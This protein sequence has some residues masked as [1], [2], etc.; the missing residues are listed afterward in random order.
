MGDYEFITT[1]EKKRRDKK[2]RSNFTQAVPKPTATTAVLCYLPIP[3]DI[4]Y[5]IQI[6]TEA[7]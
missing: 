2:K 7:N 1:F 3:R 5:E 6:N 4:R